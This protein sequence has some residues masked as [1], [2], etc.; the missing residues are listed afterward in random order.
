MQ[1]YA[2]SADAPIARPGPSTILEALLRIHRQEQLSG[3]VQSIATGAGRLGAQVFPAAFLRDLGTDAWYFATMYAPD[4][5]PVAIDRLGVPLGPYPF[6]PPLGGVPRPLIEVIGRCW[7][8]QGAVM[9]EARLGVSMVVCET[10]AVGRQVRGALLAFLAHPG[11]AGVV[12]GLL[13]HAVLPAGRLVDVPAATPRD[14]V[15]PPVSLQAAA[16][17]EIAR[18]ARYNRE[19]SFVTFECDSLVDLANLGPGLLRTVRRWDL[20]GRLDSSKHVLVAVLPETGRTGGRGL[21]RRLGKLLT[22]IPVGVATFPG[23]GSNFQRLTDVAVNRA[24]R[25]NAVLRE[26]SMS[27]STSNVWSKGVRP[28][29]AETVRCPRCLTPFSRQRPTDEASE[30][31]AL[32]HAAL[33]D[34]LMVRCPRHEDEISVE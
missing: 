24:E 5:R 34:A 13:Q 11:Y 9:I 27:R 33:R 23:D 25:A 29:D 30:H 2:T 1:S 21:I 15:L 4:G 10:I 12:H 20:I 22:G 14:G 31:Q 7:G 28:G 8:G 16:D 17:T 32:V 6:I 18:A 19:V 3:L 26:S